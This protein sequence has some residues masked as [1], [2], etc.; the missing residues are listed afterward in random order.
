[1]ARE[2]AALAP[3]HPIGAAW[4]RL[5]ALGRLHA[6]QLMP[7]P[8]MPRGIWFITVYA[9]LQVRAQAVARDQFVAMMLEVIHSLDMQ[10]PTFLLGDF[11]G[12]ADPARDFLSDTGS[13]R[14]VCPLLG[15]LLGPATPWVD[16]HRALLDDVPWT[17]Q[18]VDTSARLSASRIDLILANHVAMGM[19][20]NPT[21]LQSVRDG[22]H[23]PVLL[24][25][26]LDAPV[27]LS[28]QRPLPRLPLLLGL[29]SLELG[30]SAAWEAL[31]QRWLAEPRVA[32]ALDAAVAYTASTLST[33]LL[34]ALG[35]LVSLAGGW[36]LRPR[37]RRAAYDS[38][39]LRAARRLLVDLNSLG[40]LLRQVLAGEPATWPR[41]VVQLLARIRQAGVQLPEESAALLLASVE[42]AASDQRGVIQGITKG[43]RQ[44]RHDRW[45]KSLPTLWQDR[46]RVVYHWLHGFG[47]PWG[48]IPVLDSAGLQCT[49]PVAV[50]AAVRGYWVDSVLRRHA[51]VDAAAS[52]TAFLASPFA[53]HI[54]ALQWPAP[55]WTAERVQL[56]L[57]RMREGVAP[58]SVGIPVAVW[59]ALPA[60]WQSAVA[61]LLALVET[62]GSWPAEWSQAYVVMIPKASGGSRPQDQ[63]PITVLDLLYRIWAK[64]VVQAWAPVLQ[65]CY[66]GQAALGF[67]AGAGTVHVAQLLHDIIH[68]RRRCRL[69]LWLAS[70]DVEKCYDSI[71]WWAVF[72]SLRQAG[73]EERQVRCFEAFYTA[74]L[75]RF[76]YGQVEG[77]PWCATNGLPQGCPASPD[78]LNILLEP[79]HRWALAAG[80]GVE[81]A[82]GCRVPSVSFADDVALVAGSLCEL[83][84]LIAGYL[85][86]CALLGVKVTKV[87]AWTSLPG[88][89]KVKAAEMEVTTSPT[90]KMVGIVLGANEQQ[91]T[92]AHLQPR[93]EKALAT[94]RRLRMLELPASVCSILWRTAVLPQAVY[95]CEVRD[96][97]PSQL[98]ALTSAG[99]AAVAVKAPLHLNG[100][101]APE[102]LMGPP[103]GV[104]CC[105]GAHA[106][107]AGAPTP[108][109]ACAGQSSHGRGAGPSSSCWSWHSVAR[110]PWGA[111][112]CTAGSGL[113]G[114]PQ[115]GLPT[116]FW[117]AFCGPRGS[118]SWVNCATPRGQ[119]PTGWGGVH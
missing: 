101:R 30:Q 14:P 74:L 111:G 62:E 37:V 78:L 56:I 41:A 7:R 49:S 24:E 98:A 67:R 2:G 55:A 116:G 115:H 66:L 81:V 63:R 105:Q 83:E 79:F 86:W 112:H 35:R 5:H 61:R 52:W 113:A 96:V 109:A 36:V 71:P 39:P 33:A 4:R 26:R 84:V 8:G 54:P 50:D 27:V 90:F 103:L 64:G 31:V 59:K 100:W 32:L 3:V 42:S 40:R 108:L 65:Q 69:P 45:A 76:R 70:F 106:G 102:V 11:N 97:R 88:R 118:I 10:V 110:A 95:G 119:L 25:L 58:G 16:V 51:A 72:G 85:Q 48:S 117:L 94:T 47:T 99:Q 29:S 17:F 60:T 19:V 43:L 23:S 89:W 34:A 104:H 107:G 20:Q 6:V 46:P 22:G 77:A 93:L 44:A 9:P 1:M 21:V 15:Q 28:W 87:Q 73:V 57:R 92:K 53:A 114:L 38:Q 68:M 18:N 13:R 91:A 12:S 75:R 82:P 80:H